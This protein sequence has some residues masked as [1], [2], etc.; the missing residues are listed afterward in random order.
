L[1]F[2]IDKVCEEIYSKHFKKQYDGKP[3]KR[4][5]KLLK[6]AEVYE[7]NSDNYLRLYRTL[8]V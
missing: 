5:L 3:T 2:G 6:K 1:L 8:K 7:K 4:Y